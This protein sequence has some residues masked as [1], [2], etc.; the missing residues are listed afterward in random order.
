MP[1][2]TWE[3]FHWAV[4][5]SAPSTNLAWYFASR[6]VG[7]NNAFKNIKDSYKFGL[8]DVKIPVQ[9]YSTMQRHVDN[10]LKCIRTREKPTLNV[11]IAARAQ[12]TI[13]MAVESYRRGKMLYFD[14]KKFQIV[15]KPPAA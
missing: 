7:R 12:V 15:E 2:P 11:E 8:E 5:E 4:P 14:E 9:D 13:T 10:F 1:V 6:E 3:I